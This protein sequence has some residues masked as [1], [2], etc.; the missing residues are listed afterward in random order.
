[1]SDFDPIYVN[2]ILS[3]RTTNLIQ[4]K[5]FQNFSNDK[6]KMLSFLLSA[7]IDC[8]FSIEDGLEK[9]LFYFKEE[10][11]S[12]VGRDH[13]ALFYFFFIYDISNIRSVYRNKHYNREIVYND[14]G[15]IGKNELINSIILGSRDIESSYYP[16]YEKLNALSFS[17]EKDLILKITSECFSFLRDKVSLVKNSFF[18]D[19]FE[20]EILFKNLNLYFRDKNSL[21]PSLSKTGPDFRK[22]IETNLNAIKNL[23]YGKVGVFLDGYF[24]NKDLFTLEI[25]LKNLLVDSVLEISSS[26]ELDRS[27]SCYI[28]RKFKEVTDIKSIFYLKEVVNG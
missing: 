7:G 6:E 17:G 24:L 19:L 1:M 22:E 13:F 4:K 8:I 21:L 23:E 14:L 9:S 12:L 25:N 10:L 20:K 18:H 11:V 5:D 15:S 3:L 26:D 16:L 2:S 27:I 28:L